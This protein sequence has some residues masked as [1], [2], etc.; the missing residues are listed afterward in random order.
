MNRPLTRVGGWRL[1]SKNHTAF[2][3]KELGVV[4]KSPNCI[5][6]PWTPLR[7]RVPTVKLGYGWVLQPIVDRTN[8]ALAMRLLKAELKDRY[9]D[10]HL[11]NVGW[12]DGKPVMHD[13]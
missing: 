2:K 3:N 1:I 10:L 8:T 11:A 6:N 4:I 12:W 13:W 7:V 5:L 9:C